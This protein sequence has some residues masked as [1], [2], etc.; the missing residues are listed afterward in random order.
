MTKKSI[1]Q[2]G[3]LT[4]AKAYWISILL[5]AVILILCFINTKE[6]PKAPMTNFDKVVHLVM[7]LGLSGAVF[8]DNTRYLKKRISFQR[9]FWGSF[10]FPTALSGS[11]E[12][13]QEYFTTTRTGDWM[14]FLFDG[15]GAALGLLICIALNK[16][17]K[18]SSE[19]R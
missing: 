4:T 10:I 9:I 17:L 15:I 1:F 5:C 18:E 16:R 7:F 6:L 8:F 11:I 12:I 3:F 13:M 19:R 14:D 2:T